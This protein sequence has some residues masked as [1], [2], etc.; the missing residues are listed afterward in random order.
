[1]EK[2]QFHFVPV[3]LE[4][5]IYNQTNNSREMLESFN[6]RKDFYYEIYPDNN[7][8]SNTI[9]KNEPYNKLEFLSIYCGCTWGYKGNPY[10]S[11]GCESKFW[12]LIFIFNL[13]KKIQPTFTLWWLLFFERPSHQLIFDLYGPVQTLYILFCVWQKAFLI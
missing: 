13:Q 8:F 7:R 11:T 5:R 10:L 3:V 4:G 1:M 2:M 9:S 12:L 6:N